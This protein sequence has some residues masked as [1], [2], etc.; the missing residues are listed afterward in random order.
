MQVTSCYL[1]GSERKTD[2]VHCTLSE[3]GQYFAVFCLLL[4]MFFSNISHLQ[5]SA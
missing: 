2:L 5:L 3:V 4:S 1:F